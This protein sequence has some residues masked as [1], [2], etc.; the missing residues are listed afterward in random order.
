MA[1][2]GRPGFL[3]GW[4]GLGRF[5]LV[6]L[7]ALGLGAVILQSLGPPAPRQQ[8][9]AAAGPP[10]AAEPQA[11][12]GPSQAAPPRTVHADLAGKPAG[13][14]M[15]GKPAGETV[16]PERRPGRDTPGPVAD[17][18]PALLEPAP[19]APGRSLPCIAV[20]GRAPMHVYAAGFDPT[21]TRP[22]IGILVAGIGMNQADSMAAIHTLPGAATLAVSPYAG[23][24][25][26]L[27]SAARIA[28]HE[29]LLSVPMEPQGFPMNDP[30]DHHALMPALPPQKNVMRLRWVLSRLAGY[31]GVT[32]AL[33][34]MRGERLM[35]EPEQRDAMLAEVAKRGLLF[36]DARPGQPGLKL[37][38]NRSVD[39]TIDDDPADDAS[40]DA[41]LDQLAKLARD[42]GSALGLVAVP[43][44]KTLE[45]IATWSATLLDNGLILAPVSALVQPPVKQDGNK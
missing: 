10:Q 9:Q 4:R 15:A 30:D 35:D 38:W 14:D 21:T 26:K 43:R 41:R 24:L 8:Q 20:D 31:V 19:G 17:P 29:Y 37:A 13:A 27:L 5:W 42:K 28:G 12:A 16:P 25:D 36:V 2:G 44:Q 33:G 11:A 39:V 1:V 34:P 18:D 3:S 40:L 22:R 7:T 23:S 32:N 6:V 45:R